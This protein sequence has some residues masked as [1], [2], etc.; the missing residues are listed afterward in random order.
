MAPFITIK[1]GH[2]QAN[3]ARD[4]GNAQ[5]EDRHHMSFLQLQGKLSRMTEH[6]TVII[7][8]FHS[9]RCSKEK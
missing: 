3:L 8:A 7:M 5:G 2:H 6:Y 1:V 4:T 9:A